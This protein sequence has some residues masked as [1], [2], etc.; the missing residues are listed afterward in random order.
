MWDS[1]VIA[2]D[3][4]ALA[5]RLGG[6]SAAGRR[7][8]LIHSLA[9]AELTVLE[10]ALLVVGPDGIIQH[11]QPD[12]ATSAV[13]DLV[14]AMDGSDSSSGSPPTIRYLERTQFL[15]PGFVDTHN[16]APQW[17]MRG[18]GQSLHILDVGALRSPGGE[19]RDGPLAGDRQLL[20]HMHRCVL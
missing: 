11:L 19:A 3:G 16:H 2:P 8:V 17:A 15:I 7:L 6:S 20:T 9:L 18:L 13:P 4:A 14:K 5:Y 1:V 10:N 12:V